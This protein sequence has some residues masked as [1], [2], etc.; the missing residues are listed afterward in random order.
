MRGVRVAVIVGA[1]LWAPATAAAAEKP[2]V[3][4]GAAANITP[5]SVV[6]NGTVAKGA[7]EGQFVLRNA[8]GPRVL[9]CGP[10][11]RTRLPVVAIPRHPRGQGHYERAD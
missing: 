10:Y 7:P 9:R 4:T 8:F 6:L 1:L 3:V 5:T 11:A 2:V